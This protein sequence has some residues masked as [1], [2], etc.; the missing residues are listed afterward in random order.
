MAF[1]YAG[2]AET[3]AS[4]TVTGVA[5]KYEAPP[6]I[7]SVSNYPAMYPNLPSSERGAETL[8]S[9]SGLKHATCELVVLVSRDALG[10]RGGNFDDTVA[11]IDALD[12]ALAT[13]AAANN[14]IDRWTIVPEA[15]E[16][17]WSIVATVEA[18]E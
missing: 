18:S 6:A 15:N 7:D 3:L 17:G 10:T 13:E 1:T 14:Q 11:L 9:A 12:T 2:F 8:T 4:L 16:Y 5:T